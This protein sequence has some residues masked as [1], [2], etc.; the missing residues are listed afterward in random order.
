M[1]QSSPPPWPDGKRHACAD[2][3]LIRAQQILDDVR[4]D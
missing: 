2:H 3:I 4:R 1:M